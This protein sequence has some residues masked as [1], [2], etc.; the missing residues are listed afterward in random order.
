MVTESALTDPG[1]VRSAWGAVM[2]TRALSSTRVII[3]VGD[4]ALRAWE[5]THLGEGQQQPR[6]RGDG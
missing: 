5:R 3:D 6:G 4:L 1:G 2:A